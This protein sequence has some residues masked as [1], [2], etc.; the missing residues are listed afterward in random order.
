VASDCIGLCFESLEAFVGKDDTY[1]YDIGSCT[2]Y[3]DE[4]RLCQ[5]MGKN[6]PKIA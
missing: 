6:K 1:F 3:V 2:L 4:I 5:K